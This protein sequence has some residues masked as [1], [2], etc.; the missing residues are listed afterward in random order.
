MMERLLKLLILAIAL[1]APLGVAAE[2]YPEKA[3]RFVV[4]FPPG[5]GT[6]G[7][8]R[9]LGEKLAEMWGQPV[10]ID[11][12]GGAQGSI[13]TAVGAKAAPDG[14]TITLAHSGS[15]AINPHLYSAPGYDTLKDFAAVSGGVSMP[16][17]LVVHPSVSYGAACQGRQ[18]APGD[19]AGQ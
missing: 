1:A 12:R 7:L 19:V 14:Y 2:N 8:A 6:D 10:I 5:G 18:A 4:P 17:I 15:L 13:G 16:F 3:I 11:N 9:T